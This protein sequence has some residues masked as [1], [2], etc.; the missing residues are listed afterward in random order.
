MPKTR[1]AYL[2]DRI[3]TVAQSLAA[4]QQHEP[5]WNS[6]DVSDVSLEVASFLREALDVPALERELVS[7]SQVDA[8]TL[9]EVTDWFAAVQHETPPPF[10]MTFPDGTTFDWSGRMDRLRGLLQGLNQA[11]GLEEIEVG[12]RLGFIGDAAFASMLMALNPD[13]QLRARLE[14]K[15]LE[16]L[17]LLRDEQALEYWAGLRREVDPSSGVH[18]DIDQTVAPNGFFDLGGVKD[19]RP[20][21]AAYMSRVRPLLVREDVREGRVEYPGG[22]GG[23]CDDP[24][25]DGGSVDTNLVAN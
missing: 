5:Q 10:G 19:S 17:A 13:H 8:K 6:E 4:P 3:A 2:L 22:P 14:A 20:K 24:F 12:L 18:I 7:R 15:L 16:K 1:V 9:T 23:D 21:V 25:V 11:E